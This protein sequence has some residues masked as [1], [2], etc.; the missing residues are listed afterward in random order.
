LKAK[1]KTKAIC[2]A[3]TLLYLG[4]AFGRLATGFLPL[5]DPA[6][7]TAEISCASQGCRVDT[8]P[9]RLLPMGESEAAALTQGARAR[10]DAK[11]REPG[12]R[13]I[14]FLAEMLRAVPSFLLFVG[15]AMAARH[16]AREWTL[17]AGALAW[18][19]R[20]AVAAL[21]AVLAE[22]LADTIR[23]T[24]LSPIITGGAGEL[25]LVFD[26][27]AFLSGLLLAGAAWLSV[28]AFYHVR[29]VETELAQIV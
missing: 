1:S 3:L 5:V 2:L 19:R 24:A 18:L 27:P 26:V 17:G 8:R 7:S 22:P 29:Q 6:L 28:W 9:A 14:L 16:F 4:V 13:R 12:I 21:A 15:L 23:A 11:L 10:L 25:F 20:A